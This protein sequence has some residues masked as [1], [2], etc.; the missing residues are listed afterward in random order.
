MLEGMFQSSTTEIIQVPIGSL[1]AFQA[2]ELY[3]RG[4]DNNN[5]RDIAS[6]MMIEHIELDMDGHRYALSLIHI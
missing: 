2:I 3:N 5:G 6:N 1:G 4:I